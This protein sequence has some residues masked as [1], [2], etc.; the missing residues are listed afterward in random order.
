VIT[1]GIDLGCSEIKA[2]VLDRTGQ[3]LAT[4]RTP[5]SGSTADDGPSW[6]TTVRR[7]VNDLRQTVSNKNVLVGI[8][9][10][11][12]A[13]KDGLSIFNMPVRMEGVEG[14]IWSSVFESLLPVPVLN[15][16]HAA[17]L[18]E[19]VLG[20][21]REK[22]HVVMLTLGTGVGGAILIDG[23][24]Y[25]GAIGRAGHIGHMTLRSD[26]SRDIVGTPGSLEDLFGDHTV[27]ARSHGRFATNQELVRAH[28][29]GDGHATRIWMDSVRQL[30]CGIA[31]ITNILD[32]ELIVLGGGITKA[33]TTLFD[34]LKSFLHD[35][36]WRPNGHEVEI[37]PALL[38]TWA[39]AIGAGYRAFPVDIQAELKRR[40]LC[41]AFVNSPGFAMSVE[42]G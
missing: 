28:E 4:T 11:G 18:A 20:A 2:I 26:F 19:A 15:D 30:A 12:L 23:E 32:P 9:A 31:S 14:L 8:A 25:Q 10:P 6:L 22:K 27:S 16:A 13:A 36:E 21:A 35:V 40:N 29:K 24:L 7:L 17:L 3:V 33:G 38:G 37:V 39:G 1:V 5:T 41:A 34:P 42:P